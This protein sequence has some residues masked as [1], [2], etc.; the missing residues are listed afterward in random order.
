MNRATSYIIPLT[1]S[2]GISLFPSVSSTPKF[3]NTPF[4]VTVL[5]LQSHPVLRTYFAQLQLAPVY[6]PEAD[7][8]SYRQNGMMWPTECTVTMP[9][10][11][12]ISEAQ[13]MRLGANGIQ[14]MPV[15]YLEMVVSILS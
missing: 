8:N 12:K 4:P 7:F 11:R 2:L 9:V 10:Y 1:F 13:E 14:K 3:N 6:V 15:G 5:P